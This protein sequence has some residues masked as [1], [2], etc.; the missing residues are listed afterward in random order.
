[1]KNIRKNVTI[2]FKNGSREI[3]DAISIQKT[4]IYVGHIKST[5][6]VN[7]FIDNRFIP[8]SHVK[9]IF[10]SKSNKFFEIDYKA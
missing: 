9:K 10:V 4:G 8:R 3:F 7:E 5:N 2:I 1:M 6:K